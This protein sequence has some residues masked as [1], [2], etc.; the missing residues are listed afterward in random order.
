MI[1]SK[2]EVTEADGLRSRLIL[3]RAFGSRP[4][5]LSV[6]RCQPPPALKSTG[7]SYVGVRNEDYASGEDDRR[8]EHHY[9]RMWSVQMVSNAHGMDCK[10][11]R[12]SSL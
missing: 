1:G 9:N 6:N 2:V 7:R 10:S 8:D 11:Q 5:G 3:K 4:A 12:T